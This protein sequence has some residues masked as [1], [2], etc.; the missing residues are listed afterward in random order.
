MSTAARPAELD[1]RKVSNSREFS[2]SSR[3]SPNYNVI[4]STAAETIKTTQMSTEEGK[5]ATAGVLAR[6]PKRL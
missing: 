5:S 1:S 6:D 3:N 2:N 4:S